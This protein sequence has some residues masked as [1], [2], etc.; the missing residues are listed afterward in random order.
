MR[1][2]VPVWESRVSPVFDAAEEL[3]ISDF[4]NGR[5]LSSTKRSM[6]GLSPEQ[7]AAQL[8]KLDVDV[9]LC[10]AISRSL[11]DLVGALGVEV[12]PWVRG[13]VEG[14][15]EWY[16][17]GMPADTRLFMPGCGRRRQ[18]CEKRRRRGR[19]EKKMEEIQ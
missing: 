18:R 4:E 13:E 1:M 8:A 6:S 17:S 7:R 15:L 14:V 3:L 12:I 19:P 9:L 11:E 2:A 16:L 5:E 10:G